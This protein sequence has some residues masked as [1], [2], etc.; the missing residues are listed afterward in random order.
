MQMSVEGRSLISIA[1]ECVVQP[2]FLGH[3]GAYSVG[4][5]KKSATFQDSFAP[6]ILPLLTVSGSPWIF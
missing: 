2:L 1:K 3:S 4:G 5:E 6:I